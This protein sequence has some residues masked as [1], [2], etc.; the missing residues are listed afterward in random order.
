MSTG[1]RIGVIVNKN[2]RLF[3]SG[4]VTRQ[5]LEKILSPNDLIIETARLEDLPAAIQRFKDEGIRVIA[6]PGGDGSISQ[7]LSVIDRIFPKDDYPTIIIT[8]G[9]TNNIICKHFG[10]KHAQV[11]QNLE[12]AIKAVHSGSAK[13][14]TLKTI[15]GSR[16]K[17]DS[18]V[19]VAF[20]CGMSPNFL[21]IY[22]RNPGM[23]QAAI[24]MAKIVLHVLITLG[25]TLFRT[26]LLK[27]LLESPEFEIS[28]DGKSL[29]KKKMLLD[30]AA[31]VNSFGFGTKLFPKNAA[32]PTK[33]F[34]YLVVYK[35]LIGLLPAMLM[36]KPFTG[37]QMADVDLFINDKVT[38][39]CDGPLDFFADGELFK[40]SDGTLTMTQG[41]LVPVVQV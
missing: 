22:N 28:A 21:K 4:V 17:E 29:G 32:N 40:S 13:I 23:V 35:Q 7:G 15:L 37:G 5:K 34:Q 6:L 41:P 26:P 2:A 16:G 18:I 12:S 33:G 38:I 27:E 10:F 19:G 24:L 30:F 14:L 25:G 1:K 3:K 39:K 31:T 9:G 36:L 8:G 20:G 11:E